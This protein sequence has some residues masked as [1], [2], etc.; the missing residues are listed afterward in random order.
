MY[1]NTLRDCTNLGFIF[2]FL[3]I[4]LLFNCIILRLTFLLQLK[5]CDDR[6]EGNRVEVSGGDGFNV[7]TNEA[8]GLFHIHFVLFLC[9][10]MRWCNVLCFCMVLDRCNVEVGDNGSH[11]GRDDGCGWQFRF[12]VFYVDDVTYQYVI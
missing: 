12:R 1:F 11:G 9:V 3:C 7:L 6:D 8:Q 5:W 4:H 10:F 2:L